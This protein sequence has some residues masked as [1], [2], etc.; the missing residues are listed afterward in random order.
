MRYTVIRLGECFFEQEDE[1]VPYQQFK[2]VYTSVCLLVQQG[3]PLPAIEPKGRDGKNQS[4]LKIAQA[5]LQHM[6]QLLEG[7]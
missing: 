4:T 3:N 6:K 2:K 7:I 1:I 5:H